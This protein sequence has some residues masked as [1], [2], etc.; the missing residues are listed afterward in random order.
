MQNEKNGYEYQPI[1]KTRYQTHVEAILSQ[2]LVPVLIQQ[3]R[4]SRGEDYRRRE[5]RAGQ[6][7]VAVTTLI[8][9]VAS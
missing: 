6:R 9:L 4:K 5:T 7:D 2:V 8:E 1:L 3:I